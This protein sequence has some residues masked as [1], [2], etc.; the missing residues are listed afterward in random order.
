[1]ERKLNA[2]NHAE[3]RDLLGAFALGAVDAE[4]AAAVRAYV[5]TN[6]EAQEEL[7]ELMAGVDVL[8]LSITPLEPPAGLRDRIAAAA[9]AEA[10][11]SVPPAPA[12]LTAIPQ[13][14]NPHPPPH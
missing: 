4:E 12:Q 6:A 8:A 7:A 10:L 3:M 14:P 1:M 2:A 13:T 9:L 11:P 5:A